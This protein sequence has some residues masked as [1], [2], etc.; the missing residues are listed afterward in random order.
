MDNWL[1]FYVFVFLNCIW[2]KY[3]ESYGHFLLLA[4]TTVNVC[5]TSTTGWEICSAHPTCRPSWHHVNHCISE[6]K[7]LSHFWN[8]KGMQQLH[9]TKP[10]RTKARWSME[11]ET[12]SLHDLIATTTL[13]LWNVRF[14]LFSKHKF[15]NTC[16]L[17][18]SSLCVYHI[19]RWMTTW[20]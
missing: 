2:V 18:S 10:L 11:N 15:S 19:F 5:E 17:S 1:H 4:L 6:S 14:A 8:I 12:C 13:P 16:V 7:S 3:F 9:G 20:K